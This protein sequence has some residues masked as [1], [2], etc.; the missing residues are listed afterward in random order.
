MKS[1]VVEIMDGEAVAGQQI[2]IAETPVDAARL[3]TGREVHERGDEMEWVR[4]TDE[5]DAAVS[6]FA[7]K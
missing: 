3:V 1:Y 5:A 7:F 4:V 2:A 6:W